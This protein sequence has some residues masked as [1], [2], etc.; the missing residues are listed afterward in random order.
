MSAVKS[1]AGRRGDWLAVLSPGR[2]GP[3]AVNRARASSSRAAIMSLT[4]ASSEVSA[5]QAWNQS[6]LRGRRAEPGRYR[7]RRRQR[8]GIT[9]RRPIQRAALDI[10]LCS[11]ALVS[12]TQN[13]RLRRTS[14]WMPIKTKTV[15][16]REFCAHEAPGIEAQSGTLQ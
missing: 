1:Q 2:P 6:G 4:P 14:G 13:I 12:L 9:L 7:V 3:I 16:I 11:R 15:Q 8:T 10:K 5:G